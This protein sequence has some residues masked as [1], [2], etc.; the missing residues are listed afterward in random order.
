MRACTATQDPKTQLSATYRMTPATP[1]SAGVV[2]LGFLPPPNSPSEEHTDKAWVKY[3][4]TCS[5]PGPQPLHIPN[6]YNDE[7]STALHTRFGGSFSLC[8]TDP[9]NT[10]T[11]STAKYGSA[12]PP[13]TPTR[14]LYD[15]ETSMAPHLL[16]RGHPLCDTQPNKCTGQAQGQTQERPL[17]RVFGTIR[18]FL[19]PPNPTRLKY[20]RAC[21]HSRPQPLTPHN[22]YESNTVPHTRFGGPSP[23]C[24]AHKYDNQPNLI[25]HT[26]FGSHPEPCLRAKTQ[27]EGPVP[28]CPQPTRRWIKHGTTHP[29]QQP[30]HEA[31]LPRAQICQ[32]ARIPHAR[33]LIQPTTTP[34]P[35]QNPANKD[36]T[37]KPT[38][39][40]TKH[41]QE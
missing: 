14:T 25:P 22:L 2:I 34:S 9:K 20:G 26:R 35:K 8:E 23:E 36:T 33:D 21:S 30:T 3:G 38:T 4:G 39:R 10:Q 5:H 16:R 19:P 24:P 29:L 27:P 15:N 17:W 11:T 31:T 6:P 13:K 28:K 18:F 7:S 37:R 40:L 12:Q 1:A 41:P 32:S